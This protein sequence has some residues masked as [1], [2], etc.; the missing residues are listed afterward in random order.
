MEAWRE[1]T[2][3]VTTA[4]ARMDMVSLG[5]GVVVG[6]EVVAMVIDFYF[7]HFSFVLFEL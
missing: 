2:A 4:N 3:P 7:M 5:R 1:N 6:V